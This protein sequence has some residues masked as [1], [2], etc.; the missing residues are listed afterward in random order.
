MAG[1]ECEWR[2][3]VDVFDRAVATFDNG[4]VYKTPDTYAYISLFSHLVLLEHD[5]CFQKAQ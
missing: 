1:M 3:I 4:E 2:S 5:H